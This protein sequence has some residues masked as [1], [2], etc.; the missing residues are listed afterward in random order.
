MKTAIM[1]IMDLL[2]VDADVVASQLQYPVPAVKSFIKERFIDYDTE[3][4]YCPGEGMPQIFAR[5]FAL[6]YRIHR[7]YLE[8]IEWDMSG[9]VRLPILEN[10]HPEIDGVFGGCSLTMPGGEEICLTVPQSIAAEFSMPAAYEPIAF[11]DDRKHVH[12]LRLE[13]LEGYRL[14][15]GLSQ[16]EGTDRGAINPEAL[17]GFFDIVNTVGTVKFFNDDTR[18]A[19]PRVM[20]HAYIGAIQSYFREYDIEALSK[21]LMTVTVTLVTGDQREFQMTK[22]YSSI[23]AG[24]YR[25]SRDR[26]L[27]P[28]LILSEDNW[29]EGIPIDRIA[30]ISV[31]WV[32]ISQYG[33]HVDIDLECEGDGSTGDDL[34]ASRDVEDNADTLFLTDDLVP[35]GRKPN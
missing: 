4:D 20:S 23:L 32:L 19:F 24:L 5:D 18:K 12:I 22:G 33:A 28:F 1:H 6:E 9:G 13:E 7:A 30:M 15:Q 3:G 8:N 2:G 17:Q 27:P 34:I 35:K 11:L 31:P 21:E 29:V 16:F 25:F 10:T 26:T 14:E